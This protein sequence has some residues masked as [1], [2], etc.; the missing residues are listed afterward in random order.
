MEKLMRNIKF[1]FLS[2]APAGFESGEVDFCSEVELKAWQDSN[3][4]KIEVLDNP[5]TKAKKDKK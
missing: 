3:E 5:N 2:K 1:K 4:Y